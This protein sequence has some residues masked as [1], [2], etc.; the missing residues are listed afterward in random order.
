MKF[1]V[2]LQKISRWLDTLSEKVGTIAEW[3]ST[4]LVV[5]I[6]FDVLMRYVFKLSSAA[7][8]ELE[9]HLFSIIFL[10][11]A[12]NALK[13]DKHVRVDIFYQRMSL[14]KKAIVN[15][16]GTLFFIIPFCLIV[17]KGCIPYIKVSYLMNEKSTDPSGLPMRYVSKSLIL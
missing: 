10:F 13:K 4:I 16:L 12:S 11:G 15:L 17:I 3:T 9:W 5:L 7:L 1:L 6:C 14:Q 8:Y 2:L